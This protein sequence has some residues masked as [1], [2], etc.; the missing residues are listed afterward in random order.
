MC[1]TMQFGKLPLYQG[2]KEILTILRKI[3]GMFFP[4]VREICR[5]MYL[6]NISQ[7]VSIWA[8]NVESVGSFM[9]VKNV[10]E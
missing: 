2:L 3:E 6:V 4:V 10:N 1:G 9:Y 8:C 5:S 7:Q